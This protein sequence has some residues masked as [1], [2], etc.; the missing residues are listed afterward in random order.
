MQRRKSIQPALIARMCLLAVMIALVFVSMNFLFLF[1]AEDEFLDRTLAEEK[2]ELVA[3]YEETGQWKPPSNSDMQLYFAREALP[4]GI[5]SQLQDNP[6]QR[7]FY[8]AEGRHYHIAI[9][10]GGAFLV[11][12]VSGKLIIRNMR[13]TVLLAY[14]A[15]ALLVTIVAAALAFNLSRTTIE[16]I[17]RLADHVSTISP[18][19]A[20]ERFASDYPENEVGELAKELETSLARIHAFSEREAQFS[21]DVSHDLRTPLAVLTGALELLAEPDLDADRRDQLIERISRASRHMS[22]TVSALFAMAREQ[23]SGQPSKQNMARAV[24]TTILTYGQLLENKDVDLDVN[25]APGAQVE[26]HEGVLEIILSNVLG[27]AFQYTEAGSIAI[28]YAEPRLTV[29]DTGPGV[30]DTMR[31]RLFEPSVQGQNSSG[32]GL[33]LSIVRRLCERHGIAIRVDHLDDGTA[34]ELTF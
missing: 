29:R 23:R 21:R 11:Y 15:L 3:A 22:L 2:A 30:P 26:L 17:T 32:Y 8:G 9:L 12:E 24:E 31:E 34:I 13:T 10:E 4:D 14:G 1:T 7:E 27:N 20:P 5:G 6:R 25:V 16:P 28:T 33:G 18:A 19:M